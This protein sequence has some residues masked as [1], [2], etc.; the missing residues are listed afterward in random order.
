[1]I[2]RWHSAFQADV[3]G[4]TYHAWR[5]TLV[6]CNDTDASTIKDGVIPGID[7]TD[8]SGPG[9]SIDVGFDAK[10]S[11]AVDVDEIQRD[12]DGW[13]LPEPDRI[14]HDVP[15][16][17]M[18]LRLGDGTNLKVHRADGGAKDVLSIFWIGDPASLCGVQDRVSPS[19]D[20]EREPAHI[21]LTGSRVE[22]PV[23]FFVEIDV[24][25][26]DDDLGRGDKPALK[27]DAHA[28]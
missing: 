18:G 17:L 19:L 21:D 27:V 11:L 16:V 22:A 7:M 10:I 6:E 2:T 23:V 28:R 25:Q 5:Q 26:E 13:I 3:K 4:V 15:V 14:E 1:M 9:D 12:E 24:V 20:M 8:Q